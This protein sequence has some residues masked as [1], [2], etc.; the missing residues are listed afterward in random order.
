MGYSLD[1][2]RISELDIMWIYRDIK[3]YHLDILLRDV[4]GYRMDIEIG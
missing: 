1:N 2:L 4:N 3:G